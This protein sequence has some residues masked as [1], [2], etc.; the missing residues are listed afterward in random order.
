MAIIRQ[1]AAA[2]ERT[3]AELETA[4]RAYRQTWR[5]RKATLLKLI[6]SMEKEAKK[7][8]R[9]LDKRIAA[10]HEALDPAGAVLGEE[11][12]NWSP[13]TSITDDMSIEDFPDGDIRDAMDDLS[14]V[15]DEATKYYAEW[16]LE[17]EGEGDGT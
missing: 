16:I 2:I 8:A 14:S 3:Q 7:E 6:R 17:Q 12:A 5:D 4:L 15:K 10:F 1:D 9:E 13:T 11:F